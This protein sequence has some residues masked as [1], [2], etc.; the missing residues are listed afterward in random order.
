[1]P[2]VSDVTRDN[3]RDITFAG[4]GDDDTTTC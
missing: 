4:H 1:V 3:S 2:S